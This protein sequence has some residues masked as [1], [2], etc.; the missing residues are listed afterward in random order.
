VDG[1][2]FIDIEAAGEGEFIEAIREELVE[3]SYRPSPVKRKMIP[4]ANGKMRPLQNTDA[5]RI[6]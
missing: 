3:K 4:K 2:T 1:V 5:S 6:G